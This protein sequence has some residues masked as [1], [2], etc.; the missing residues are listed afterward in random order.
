MKQRATFLLPDVHYEEF[1]RFC[2]RGS[3]RVTETLPVMIDVLCIIPHGNRIRKVPAFEF[4]GK[5]RHGVY[6][7]Q[8]LPVIV[9]GQAL[10]GVFLFRPALASRRAERKMRGCKLKHGTGQNPLLHALLHDATVAAPSGMLPREC[11]AKPKHEHD[12]FWYMRSRCWQC[13]PEP[14][15]FDILCPVF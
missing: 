3:W 4:G 8:Y 1:N 11:R 13:W 2:C 10:R 5:S 15:E 12:M 7:N 14:P 6:Q 9:I